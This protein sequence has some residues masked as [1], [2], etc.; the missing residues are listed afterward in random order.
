MFLSMKAFSPEL[1]DCSIKKFI[2][3]GSL[4]RRDERTLDRLGISSH[5]FDSKINKNS[6]SPYVKYFTSGIFSKFEAFNQSDACN[7][8]IWLDSDQLCLRE[9]YGLVD[10]INSDFFVVQSSASSTNWDNFYSSEDSIRYINRYIDDLAF[11]VDMNDV[12]I[13]AGFFGVAP[14]DGARRAYALSQRIFQDLQSVL[15]LPDQGVIQILMR[16]CF[17]R[18]SYLDGNIFA[19]HSKEW[20]LERLISADHHRLPFFSHCYGQPKYWNGYDDYLWKYFYLQW[21]DL[22]GTPFARRYMLKSGLR[23]IIRKVFT[24]QAK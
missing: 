17:Q 4:S 9:L 22:G 14:G 12:G 13:S 18:I 3:C 16:E 10:S 8:S 6:A 5:S 11:A 20:P 23:N 7:Y 21:L 1:F 2:H 15:L 19:P 24:A